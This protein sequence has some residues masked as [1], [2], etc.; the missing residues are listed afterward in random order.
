MANG[1]KFNKYKCQV[2]HI[3]HNG[4]MQCYRLGTECLE[5]RAEEKDL[6]VLVNTW[7]NM[8]Q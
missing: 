7:L 8:S 3:G 4:P 6:G 1:L 2:L 5:D